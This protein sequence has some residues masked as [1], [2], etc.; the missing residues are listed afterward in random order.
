MTPRKRDLDVL[1]ALYEYGVDVENRRVWLVGEI[2]EES[3]YSAIKGLYL[4]DTINDRPV[5]LFINSPGG[6]IVEALAVYDIVQTLKCPVWTFAFGKCESAAPLLLSMGEPGR[7][8]VA[9]N[10][11]LMV[12]NYSSEVDGKGQD[13]RTY[14]QQSEAVFD[15]YLD[16]LAGHSNQKVSFWKSLVRRASDVYFDSE[17]AIAWGIADSV[18]KER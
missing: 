16:L 7:R 18:W 3:A 2:T 5:E 11:E 12:H 1:Q 15:R 4:L 6:D 9:A 14:I 17:Q 10:M 8:W 13:L